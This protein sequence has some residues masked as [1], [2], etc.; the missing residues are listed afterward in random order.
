MFG[1]YVIFKKTYLIE[2]HYLCNR[3]TCF[4][5]AGALVLFVVG[6]TCNDTLCRYLSCFRLVSLF[7]SLFSL[8]IDRCWSSRVFLLSTTVVLYFWFWVVAHICIFLKNKS[9]VV[10]RHYTPSKRLCTT[11][12]YWIVEKRLLMANKILKI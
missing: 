10:H 4:L 6:E 9:F 8:F 5:V 3:I 7:F 2:L 1:K 11:R 12:Y